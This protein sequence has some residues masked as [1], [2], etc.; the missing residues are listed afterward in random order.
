MRSNPNRS[1]VK[2]LITL[3]HLSDLHAT[4]PS[5]ASLAALSSKRFFGW[6][7]WNLRRS[8]LY[9]REIA[10]ALLDDLK[11]EAPD[12]VALTG[13]LINISLPAEFKAAAGI[14]R[15][16]GTPDWVT[17][18]PG[19]HDAYVDMPF[20]RAWAHWLSYLES[21]PAESEGV[22]N[23]AQTSQ[24]PN[25]FSFPGRLPSVRIRGDLALIG[26]CTA[27]PTKLFFAGGQVG[28]GQLEQLESTLEALRARD[29]CRVVLIHHP[30]VDGHVARRR[31]LSDSGALR[32]VLERAGAELVI[33]GHNHRS[34]F[35]SLAGRDG[36]IPIVGVRS[37]SY[38]GPNPKKTA[39]YHIYQFERAT[40]D[41]G[42]RFGV[43]LRVREWNARTRRFGEVGIA[44]A[45]PLAKG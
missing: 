31:R 5:R 11:R 24:Y 27:L 34:E 8:R 26:V 19:N 2:P 44:R 43:S 30:V 23:S 21:D 12:H 20:E 36:A 13:D 32:E 14:L 7:S 4:D 41:T 6:L 29:L 37:G 22:S 39:Q 17:L 40:S 18:V 15:A 38:G 42:S 45:L 10:T 1:E 28:L 25:V 16:L 3:G 9:K 33:H 35:K